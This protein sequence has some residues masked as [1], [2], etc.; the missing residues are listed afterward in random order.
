M[1][2]EFKDKSVGLI[3]KNN[4]VIPND[5]LLQKISIYSPEIV[6]TFLKLNSDIVENWLKKLHTEFISNKEKCDLEDPTACYNLGMY[7]EFEKNME[8]YEKGGS[9]EIKLGKN[10]SMW[11]KKPSTISVN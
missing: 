8:N 7:E 1:I 10:K 9:I 5:A 4:K 2:E 6:E 3:I 11:V